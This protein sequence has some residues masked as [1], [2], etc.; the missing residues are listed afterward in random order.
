MKKVIEILIHPVVYSFLATIFILW[1]LTMVSCGCKK[2]PVTPVISSTVKIDQALAYTKD[3]KMDTTVAIFV[4]FSQPARMQR[5]SLIDLQSKTILSKTQVSHGMG[6]EF[7]IKPRFSNVE[8]SHLSSLGKYK[9]GDRGWSMWGINIKYVLHGLESTND[10]AFDRNIVLHSWEVIPDNQRVKRLRSAAKG[11]GCPA[12]SNAY[13][14]KLD[15]ILKS[16]KNVL[17]WIYK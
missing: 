14:Q 16:R 2:R 6:L 13:M 17:L 12:V 7:S 3:N 15:K 8:G 10:N 1:V 11:Y 9:I 5:M 4:D